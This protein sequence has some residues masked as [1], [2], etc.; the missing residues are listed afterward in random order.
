MRASHS[1][2]ISI[3]TFL[4]GVAVSMA[5]YQFVYVPEANAK[6]IFPKAMLEP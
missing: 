6:P 3:M 2:G 4:I 5:Y 1:A